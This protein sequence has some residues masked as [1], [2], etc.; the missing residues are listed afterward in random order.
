MLVA[1]EPWHWKIRCGSRGL[2]GFAED[3]GYYHERIFLWPVWR[4]G[5]GRAGGGEAVTR[6]V[7][8]G[9]GDDG[10]QEHDADF[11]IHQQ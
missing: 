2:V 7:I 8:P 11:V 6:H 9:E 5:D 4:G 10:V 3:P 1:G